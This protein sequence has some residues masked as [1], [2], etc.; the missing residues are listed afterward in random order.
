MLGLTIPVTMATRGHLK[1]AQNHKFVLIS[2]SKF[3]SKCCNFSM[4]GIESKAFQRWLHVTIYN[5]PG[6]I[7]RLSQ[8]SNFLG[9]EGGC[10]PLQTPQTEG[11]H[12]PSGNPLLHVSFE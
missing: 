12:P 5:R 7:F 10:R 1:I 3:V 4:D 2:P 11:T 8:V 6:V 9:D